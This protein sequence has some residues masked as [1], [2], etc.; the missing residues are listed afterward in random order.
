MIQSVTQ[1]KIMI[2]AMMCNPV[3]ILYTTPVMLSKMFDNVIERCTSNIS[4]QFSR[5][6]QTLYDSFYIYYPTKSL[7][8]LVMSSHH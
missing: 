4:P 8:T 6:L 7:S 2:I 3:N 1:C 5:I